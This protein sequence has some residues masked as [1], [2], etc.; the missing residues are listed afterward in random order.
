MN[1]RELRRRVRAHNARMDRLAAI[2][3]PANE[4]EAICPEG[5]AHIAE[6]DRAALE[7]FAETADE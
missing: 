1:A 5:D 6:R 2:L 3:I 4:P 7:L